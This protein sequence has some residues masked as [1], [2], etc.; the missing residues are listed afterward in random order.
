MSAV[1]TVAVAVA[2]CLAAAGPSSAATLPPSSQPASDVTLTL[3]N[4][5]HEDLD[6]AMVAGFTKQTGIK[7][8]MRNGDDFELANQ[9]VQEGKASPADV[10]ITENSP[11]M[12]LVDGAKG[13]SPRS[14][15]P[16]SRRCPRSSRRRTATGSAFAARS[17]VLVVQHDPARAG[18]AADV[19]HGPGRA[20]VEG[21]GRHR[22]R[23][24][25]TSRPSSAPS[26]ALEGEEAAA[27]WLKGL[28]DNAKVYRGNNAVMQAVNDGEIQ[29]GVI[30]HYYWY[31]DQA[32]SGENSN[33]TQL[34]FFGNQDPGAFVSVSGAGVLASQQAPEA[35]PSSCVTLPHRRRG[36]EDPRRQHRDGVPDRPAAC[37]QPGAQA[38]QR[39]RPAD[40]RALHAQRPQGR[41]S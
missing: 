13:C 26:L 6:E 12:T 25:P 5:Q 23:P 28:K 19:D 33:N 2:G 41:S 31:K 32:E 21:Q 8:D 4:A 39:A 1:L 36:P 11:A 10:F 16:R 14:T 18:R 38:A 30:Y 7:V 40:R 9:I 20:G 37:R 35:R 15:R 24:A 27:T 29:A 34:H 17:T 3:Y 22:R